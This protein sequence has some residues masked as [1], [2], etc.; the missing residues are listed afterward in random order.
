MK[1]LISNEDKALV[2]SE[3]RVLTRAE[4]QGLAE[5]PPEEEWFA[6][7]KN[8]NTRLAYQKD[9]KEFV[10]FLGLEGRHELQMVR[11]AHVIAWRTM[12]ENR[13]PKFA[14]ATTRRKLSAV[15]SLFRYL[16]EQQAV[17]EN[18]VAGIERPNPDANTG[19]TPALG[20]AQTR[21][22]LNAPDTTTLLGKRDAAIL[23]LLFYSAL[24]REEI[25]RLKM[26]CRQTNKGIPSLKVFGKGDK[27]R[28]VELAPDT[29]AKLDDYLAHAGLP[30][31]GDSP[32]FQPVKIR[33]D[34]KAVRPLHVNSIF[35]N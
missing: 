4:F 17:D 19:K 31:D 16:C 2:R 22:L 26:K 3:N 12:L 33:S 14:P 24:R 27:T 35:V 32:L 7:I 21:R 20:D 11:R 25:T 29:I 30:T 13:E 15:S 6:N 1:K 5:V 9:V 8:R 10:K 23:S 28:W 34:L 18:P